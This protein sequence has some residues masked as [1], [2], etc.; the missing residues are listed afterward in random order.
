M[1]SYAILDGA[2]VSD[3]LPQLDKTRPEFICLYRGELKPDLAM[4]A[5]Y[6]VKLEPESEFANW[7]LSAG[8]GKHWGVFAISPAD[9]TA[10]RQ[11]FRKFLTVHNEAGKPLIFRY[12]DPRVMRT[13]LPTCEPGELAD[14]FGPVE[15]FVMEGEDPAKMLQFALR[16]SA[17]AKNE[18]P[19]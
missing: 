3:L 8:W 11:H 7:V 10:I 15:G 9:L 6:L 13:F 1:A 16:A 12:Y 4:A 5:P 18:S 14:F 17:L 2:S 19:V